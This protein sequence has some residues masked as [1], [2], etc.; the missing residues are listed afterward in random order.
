LIIQNQEVVEANLIYYSGYYE[1]VKPGNC[2]RC[3][4][5]N[6]LISIDNLRYW[7]SEL[8]EAYISCEAS[9]LRM[10]ENF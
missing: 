10:K 3:A 5:T 1:I 2:V 4:V 8:Q 9:F 6:N 7:N